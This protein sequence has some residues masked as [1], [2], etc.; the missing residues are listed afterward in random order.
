MKIIEGKNKENKNTV[1]FYEYNEKDFSIVME[2]CDENL[3]N[4]NI[5][6][7]QAFQIKEIYEL[8]TQLNNTFKIMNDNRI[9]HRDLK[10]DNI[11][12]KYENKEKTKYTYKISDYGISK[13]LIS[14]S[15]QFSTNAGTLKYMA[16]EI[17][18]G[19]KFETKCDLWSLGVII[20]SLLFKR[21]PYNGVTDLAIINQIKA[22][23]QNSLQKTNNRDMDDLIKRLLTEDPKNRISWNDYF[24]HSFFK[25]KH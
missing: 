14:L 15:R 24:N 16:P 10:P 11:L 1:K 23:G 18:K 2:L 5:K 4:F 19:E 3:T 12:I 6:K 7:K 9:A 8:L 22:D 13:Q 21:F 25:K 17:L 20:Y